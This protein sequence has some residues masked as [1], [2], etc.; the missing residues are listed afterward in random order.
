MKPRDLPIERYAIAERVAIIMEACDV[1]EPT[2]IRMAKEQA[3]A[4][5][6]R[7]RGGDQVNLW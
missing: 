2:A 5:E 1:D 4:I 3:E 6:R 7:K